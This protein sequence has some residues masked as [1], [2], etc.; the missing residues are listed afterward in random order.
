MEI[1][2]ICKC[3]FNYGINIHIEKLINLFKNKH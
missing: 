1:I 3:F 2:Y